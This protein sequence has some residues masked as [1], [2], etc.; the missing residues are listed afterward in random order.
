MM[1]QKDYVSVKPG[2]NVGVITQNQVV[3]K[4]GVASTVFGDQ[5]NNNKKRRFLLR[6]LRKV[7]I[8]AGIY[9]SSHNIRKMY[10]F[11]MKLS[12]GYK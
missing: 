11:L 9:F 5:M 8:E 10:Q 4:Y 1:R 12:A 3:L 6:S 7:D 2:Y